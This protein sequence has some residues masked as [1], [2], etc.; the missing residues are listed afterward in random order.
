MKIELGVGEESLLR[1]APWSE[2]STQVDDIGAQGIVGLRSAGVEL[3]V[4]GKI[5]RLRL[6]GDPS[7]PRSHNPW[8][9]AN[10]KA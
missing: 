6:Y 1:A 2:Y 7:N 5:R 4:A 9:E 3:R 10:R 8:G